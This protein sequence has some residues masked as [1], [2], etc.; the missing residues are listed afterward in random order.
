MKN[1]ILIALVLSL[2]VLGT[3]CVNAIQSLEMV[4]TGVEAILPLISGPAHIPPATTVQIQMYLATVSVATTKA[5][6]ILNGPG[7]NA[8]KATLIASA[9]AGISKPLLPPGTPQNIASLIDLISKGVSD[10]LLTIS[11]ANPKAVAAVVVAPKPAQAKKLE[12][13]KARSTEA[14]AKIKALK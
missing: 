3:G 7:T 13:V 4:L 10:Y 6:D 1:K 11:P 5:A 2:S 12:A 14:T 8:Q 9:F